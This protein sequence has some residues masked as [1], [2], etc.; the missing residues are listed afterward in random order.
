VTP[1]MRHEL[2]A[3]YRELADREIRLGRHRRAAYI[4]A[5]L[6]GDWAASAATLRTGGYYREAATLYQERLQR[7]RDAAACLEEDG[8]WNEAINLYEKLSDYEKVGQL[9]RKIEQHEH[10]ESAYRKAVA[11]HLQHGDRTAA[12]RLGWQAR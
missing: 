11:Q 6:L 3:R 2:A 9:Y 10:A 4:Y 5:T 1:A 8:A 12:A 7:P